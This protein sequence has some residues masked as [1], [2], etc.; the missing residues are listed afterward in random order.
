MLECDL[1]VIESNMRAVAAFCRHRPK[2][3]AVVKADAYGH[4]LIPV[5][6]RVL[7]CGAD[8]LAVA[9]IDEAADLRG[10][11]IDA[12][13]LILGGTTD[14]GLAEAVRLHVAQAVY[15]VH[16]LKVLQ[17]QAEIQ[18]RPALAHLKID[19]GMS[20]IGVRGDD[21]LTALL[22]AWKACA[23][24]R[25]EGIFTHLAAADEADFT[26]M[27]FLR[28]DRAI[29]LVN[30]AG[31][32]PM[33]HASASEGITLG[34][35]AWYDAVRP[36]I[37][38]YGCAVNARLPG[39]MPAQTLSTRPVRI[40]RIERGETVGYGR[41]FRAD[42][43][44]TVMTLPVGYGDG[45]PRALSNKADVLIRG[46][47]ARVIGRVCMDQLMVDVTD[48]PEPSMQDTVVLMGR[49][50]DER[51]TPDELAA[52]S[53]TIPWEIMLGFS[54]RVTRSIKEQRS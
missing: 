25:M 13:I 10:A 46:R 47:R 12:P 27:Q 15:D 11:G 23:G 29:D 37:A 43:E 35:R 34:E 16:A 38:L 22:D 17:K 18:Q 54:Q 53:G 3:I 40:A 36:G 19:T 44:M 28:F 52:L 39:I 7:T 24:V 4:G 51:I 2:Q 49:Q 45:Y 26:D 6:R 32:R 42:R 20:R 21:D 8:A 1:S 30:R 9:T 50:G 48:L 33:R 31:Y 5:S 14:E 41:T